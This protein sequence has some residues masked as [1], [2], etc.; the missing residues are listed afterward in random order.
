MNLVDLVDS[1]RSGVAVESFPSEVA[2]S[3]YTKNTG[4]F[5]PRDNAHAGGLLK[6]LLRRIDHPRTERAIARERSKPKKPRR[7]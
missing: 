6:F 7:K 2:L 3:E 1:K 4:K 5:F